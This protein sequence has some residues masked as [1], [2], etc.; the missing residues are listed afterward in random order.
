MPQA[1]F[2]QLQDLVLQMLDWVAREPRRY[3]ETMEAWG[4]YCPGL[5]VWEEAA[6]AGL[7][8]VTPSGGGLGAAQVAL[9]PAGFALLDGGRR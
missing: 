7:V 9:T 4:T 8:Q 1:K 5:A 6:G 3:A 2:D